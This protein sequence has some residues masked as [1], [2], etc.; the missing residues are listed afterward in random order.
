MLFKKNSYKRKHMSFKIRFRIAS[1]N[2]R[3]IEQ[4]LNR[5]R[6]IPDITEVSPEFAHSNDPVLKTIFNAHL[7]PDLAPHEM[8]EKVWE[9]RDVEGVQD[10]YLM[11]V[12][13]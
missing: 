12:S 8:E 7:N 13:L 4:A 11:E 3:E 6:G 9:V 10:S 2:R 1:E 5:V